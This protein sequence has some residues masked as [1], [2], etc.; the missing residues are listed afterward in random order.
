MDKPRD[1]KINPWRGTVH[2]ET[3]NLDAN[4]FRLFLFW[5]RVNADFGYDSA[6]D[7]NE[8]VGFVRV[9]NTQRHK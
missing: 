1:Q 3:L 6:M 5:V 7:I 8:V 9:E 2:R 4:L